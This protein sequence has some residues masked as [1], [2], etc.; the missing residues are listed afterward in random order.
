MDHW[1][2]ADICPATLEE[3][4]R[5]EQT[6][7]AVG[8]GGSCGV[9]L[10]RIRDADVYAAP[11]RRHGI[12]GSDCRLGFSGNEYFGYRLGG[13]HQL[14]FLRAWRGSEFYGLHD[15]PIRART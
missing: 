9:L 14:A 13:Y 11:C 15:E 12:P 2:W 1:S 8:C 5:H 6:G 10:E 7:C 3:W 4:E